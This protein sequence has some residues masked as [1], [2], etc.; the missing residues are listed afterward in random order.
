MTRP[1]RAERADG[2]SSAAAAAAAAAAP[3]LLSL[4]LSM[5]LCVSVW[6]SPSERDDKSVPEGI[7]NADQ[8]VEFFQ[9]QSVHGGAA[10][11][12]PKRGGR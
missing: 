4:F 9:A 2:V 7:T 10:A 1:D 11:G 8:V 6:S 12:A 5:C 3:D